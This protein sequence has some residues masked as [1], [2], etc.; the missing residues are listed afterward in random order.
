[1]CEKSGKGGRRPACVLVKQKYY[2]RGSKDMYAGRNVG[3]AA[4]VCKDG[5][6]KAK[7]RLQLNFA[8]NGKNKKK[9]F[10]TYVGKKRKMKEN[11]PK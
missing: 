4:W 10:Y 2:S 11:V 5:I 9:G 3:T 8:K 1:M 7:E 6:Q